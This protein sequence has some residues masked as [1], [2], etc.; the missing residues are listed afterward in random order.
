M[1]WN[2]VNSIKEELNEKIKKFDFYTIRSGAAVTMVWNAVKKHYKKSDF[3]I[4]I[5]MTKIN[6]FY[7]NSGPYRVVFYYDDFHII[8]TKIPT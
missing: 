5:V 6:P 8:L 1:D 7:D 2:D 4:Q 3:N